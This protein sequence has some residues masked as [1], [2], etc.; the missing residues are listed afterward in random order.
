[1]PDTLWSFPSV[2]EYMIH[3]YIGFTAPKLFKK[4]KY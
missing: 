2:G 4:E 3:N 1:M